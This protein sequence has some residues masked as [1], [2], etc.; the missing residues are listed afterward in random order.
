MAKEQGAGSIVI[1]ARI[2]EELAQLRS[3]ERIE[4]LESLG[5][6]EPG[7]NRMIHAGYELLRAG[8]F[9]HRRAEGSARLDHRRRHQGAGG[10]RRHSHRF[11]EGLHSRRNHHL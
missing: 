1:S 11:R 3:E 10:G 4:Y 8:D 6:S 7:L 9:F 2:E 5:L